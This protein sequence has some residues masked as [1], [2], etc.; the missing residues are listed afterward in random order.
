[1]SKK[2]QIKLNGKSYDVEVN[3]LAGDTMTLSVN[4]KA[5]NVEVE[6]SG[7]P[8]TQNQPQMTQQVVKAASPKPAQASAPAVAIAAASNDVIIAPM[9]GV[10]MDIAVKPGDK[11]EAKQPVCALE[12]MKMKNIL[13]STREG[14][15]A[16]VEVSEGQ[17]VPY[18]AV[19]IRFA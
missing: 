1:M 4:G 17:R 18:G 2:I 5:Y 3:D 10:I 13:R 11:L 12:A 7:S 16:S 19:I 8:V 15:V 6:D 9:P 14:V